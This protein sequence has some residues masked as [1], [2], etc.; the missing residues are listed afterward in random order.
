MTRRANR[1]RKYSLFR[2]KE[3]S[4]NL[5][6]TSF[7]QHGIRIFLWF[8]VTQSIIIVHWAQLKV[9]FF[10]KKKKKI[11]FIDKHILSKNKKK[12]LKN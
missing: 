3:D 2:L 4:Q 12:F 10:L 5:N 7:L 6:S 9:V 11:K 1:F 8:L